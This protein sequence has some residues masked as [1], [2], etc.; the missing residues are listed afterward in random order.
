MPNVLKCGSLNLL[1]PSGPVQAC[2][3]IAFPLSLPYL[4]YEFTP[5]HTSQFLWQAIYFSSVSCL[6]CQYRH[7]RFISCLLASSESETATSVFCRASLL[8][9]HFALFRRDNLGFRFEA[10]FFQINVL[11]ISFGVLLLVSVIIFCVDCPS[12]CACIQLLSPC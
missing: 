9:R 7:H 2:N 8:F 4:Y 5:R 3:G 1:E 12:I 6:H 10:F 11:I